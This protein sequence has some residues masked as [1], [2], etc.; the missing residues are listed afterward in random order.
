MAR[1]HVGLVAAL[2]M[3]LD[4]QQL[5]LRL[6]FDTELHFYIAGSISPS[7]I[8]AETP[9]FLNIVLLLHTK[10]THKTCQISNIS[11]CDLFLFFW[12]NFPP[13]PL[14]R[15]TSAFS[16]NQMDLMVCDFIFTNPSTFRR[17]YNK[18]HV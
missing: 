3:L 9:A 16:S 10:E 15:H 8:C 1:W 7:W 13:H 12:K 11:L 5:R 6:C 4:N 17:Y 2:I 14:F 18:K